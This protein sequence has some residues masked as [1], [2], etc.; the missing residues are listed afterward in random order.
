MLL[1]YSIGT[2][3]RFPEGLSEEDWRSIYKIAQQQSL[4]GVLFDGIRQ[5]P[6]IRLERKL[7]LKWYAACERI[8][9]GN[10]KTN[11]AAVELTRFLKEKGLRGCIL[12][13]QGNTLNY[14]NPYSRMS[15]DIDV[16]V[17]P[18]EKE[19]GRE[20]KDVFVRKMIGYARRRNPGAKACYHH[21]DAGVFK[22]IEV[23]IHYRPSFMNNLVHN[24]RLQRWFEEN[25]EEQFSHEVELPDGAGC[26]CVPTNA[27]NRI[28][29]MAHI[30]NHI[31]HE[32]IGLRQLVDYYCVLK[33]GFTEE[34]KRRDAALL[35]R[36]GL[37]DMACAVMYVLQE[38]LHMEERL[39]LVPVDEQRGRF[40]L[41][42]I[43]LAGNFGQ[44]DERVD[45]HVSQVGRNI[46]RLKRNLRLMW[47]FP[48]ECLWEPVFRWYHFFW[49][50][51]RGR[52][53]VGLTTDNRQRTTEGVDK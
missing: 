34:E 4:L 19:D 44:Y 35:R 27:F 41:K 9:Q 18:G 31:I 26:I 52:S 5:N 15:G 3:H 32:G 42:E 11:L 50:L 40:L 17:M 12:K 33:Q 39:L 8:Q 24:S 7:L 1:R 51:T 13:G 14:P 28:Y 47:Y 46:Q 49:R 29:Q 2:S 6:A 45:H 30:S 21:V 43:M 20:K 53:E 38:T 22:G 10:R 37:Y 25:A 23:E 36:F 48:S 16:W